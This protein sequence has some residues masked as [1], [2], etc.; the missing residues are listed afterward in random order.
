MISSP[1]SPDREMFVTDSG[2]GPTDGQLA[3]GKTKC[4]KVTGALR[5]FEACLKAAQSPPKTRKQATCR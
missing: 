3:R 1:S 2:N 5:G 4:A